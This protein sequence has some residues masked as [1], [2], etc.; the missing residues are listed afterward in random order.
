M[1]HLHL[2]AFLALV[3]LHIACAANPT[4]EGIVIP[5]DD[6]I[7]VFDLSTTA[8]PAPTARAMPSESLFFRIHLDH[9]AFPAN[10]NFTIT[11]LG[12]NNEVLTQIAPADLSGKLSYWT[13]ELPGTYALVKVTHAKP[14]IGQLQFRF[15]EFG[16]QA[17][18]GRFLSI[19][20][21]N[22]PK[23]E[24]LYKA[25]GDRKLMDVAKAVAKISYVK[26]G[27]M[28]S[29]T[30]FLVAKDLM[31]TNQHCLDSSPEC[32][33]VVVRFGY[34]IDAN[35][36]EQPV[37]K[38]HCIRIEASDKGLDFTLLRLTGTPGVTWGH[39]T[40]ETSVPIQGAKF[41]IVHHP[42]GMPKRV[43]IK[44]CADTGEAP[45][46]GNQAGLKSDIDHMCDT[47]D[48]SSGS[49]VFDA[50][51]RVVALHHLGFSELPPGK[52]GDRNN[53]AVLIGQ[54]RARIASFLQ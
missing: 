6:K 3:G 15:A 42:G 24:P 30:G 5:G 39:L 34:E 2:L 7:L 41:I 54:V 45:V 1:L 28:L 20:D 52:Q 26:N 4:S 38:Q 17:Q 32:E 14:A 44:D 19:R 35:R 47:E 27:T 49:P 40:L 18:G 43:T 31:L 13:D 29:C 33:T 21:L 10:A 16:V 9:I 53:Q 37:E 50:E 48:G 25:A 8:D 12:R 46:D 36:V 22:N 51:Y 23:D 11:V